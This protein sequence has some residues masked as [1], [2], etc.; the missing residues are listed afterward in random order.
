MTARAK[1]TTII[2]AA[3]F[4][5]LGVYFCYAGVK[6]AGFVRGLFIII[7]VLEIALAYSYLR[8]LRRAK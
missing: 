6:S 7:G 3:I 8:S 1:R 5:L 2:K 4:A